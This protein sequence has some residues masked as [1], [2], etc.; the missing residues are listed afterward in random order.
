MPHTT[1]KPTF[2]TP[3]NRPLTIF[4]VVE[5]PE[6]TPGLLT[7]DE[8]RVGTDGGAEGHYFVAGEGFWVGETLDV[9][10]D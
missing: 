4:V 3:H 10:V 1:P 2:Q 8:I 6:I 9:V 7:P 5:L